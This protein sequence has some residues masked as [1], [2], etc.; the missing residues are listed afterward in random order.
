MAPKFMAWPR[1]RVRYQMSF[2][3]GLIVLLC[4]GSNQ[5]EPT[6]LHQCP[7]MLDLAFF[8]RSW[9]QSHARL[10]MV[11][12]GILLLVHLPTS[13]GALNR[14]SRGANVMH[15][16]CVGALIQ[17][18]AWLAVKDIVVAAVASPPDPCNVVLVTQG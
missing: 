9:R 6:S 18:L 1:S 10:H 12:L 15:R 8:N 7:L 2:L 11:D 17:G 5:V 14:P 4:L 3:V 16:D 13:L